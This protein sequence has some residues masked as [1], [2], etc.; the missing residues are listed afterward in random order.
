MVEEEGV[1][2]SEQDAELLSDAIMGTYSRMAEFM[3]ECGQRTRDPGWLRN[4]FGRYRRFHARRDDDGDG[5]ER[6]AK[7]FIPQSGVADAVSRALD[8]LYNYPGR[9]AEDGLPKFRVVL[10][11]HDALL[12]EVRP[13]YLEWFVGTED[14][15]GVIHD[16]MTKK[17]RVYRC[18]LDGNRFPGAT[19]Y[20]MGTETAIYTHWG[21]KPRR[22]ALEALGVPELYLPPKEKPKS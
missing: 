2:L 19:P 9:F 18:D 4:C 13:K 21:E 14:K 12:F 5:P 1:V 17:V 15:P 10:Q 6:E 7:S 16:C 8:H 22:D 20:E 3:E 11:I